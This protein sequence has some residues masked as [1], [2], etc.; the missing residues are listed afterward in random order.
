[1]PSLKNKKKVCLLTHL[2]QSCHLFHFHANID[3]CRYRFPWRYSVHN[4][5]FE[6][7]GSAIS[8][9]RLSRTWQGTGA[10]GRG[11]ASFNIE[12]YNTTWETAHIKKMHHPVDLFLCLVSTPYRQH[13]YFRALKVSSM[14]SWR[15]LMLRWEMG[16]QGNLSIVHFMCSIQCYI[17]VV[18]CPM[19][20]PVLSSSSLC[21]SFQQ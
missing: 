14:T 11:R 12:Q 5:K 21:P 16:R 15:I 13:P 19:F 4:P 1:M 18:V 7:Q 10:W 17:L 9:G 6:G 20:D 8:R 3:E 2:T